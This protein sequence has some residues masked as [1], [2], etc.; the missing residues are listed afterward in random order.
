MEPG[1]RHPYDTPLSAGLRF[2]VELIAWIAG[3]WAAALASVWL[4]IPVAVT[5][6]GLPAVFSTPGDK[7]NV[8]VA[9]P[10]PVRVVIEL[11]LYSVAAFA[12][13]FVWSEGMAAAASGVVVV[14]AV[15]GMPRLAW[16]SKG[17][18]A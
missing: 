17:A 15:L 1:E 9:T 5:L 18:P 14:S 3:P 6:V 2:S 16:L 7:R 8:I 11:L 13:W 10:G 4:I 12:P